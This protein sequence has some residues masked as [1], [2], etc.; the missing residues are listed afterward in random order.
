MFYSNK[1][2]TFFLILFCLHFQGAAVAQVGKTDLSNE[3]FGANSPAIADKMDANVNVNFWG[4]NDFV[5][6]L[7]KF[8]P[9]SSVEFTNAG[10]PSYADRSKYYMATNLFCGP[11]E[12]RDSSGHRITLKNPELGSAQSYPEYYSLSGAYFVWSRKFGLKQ[13]SGPPFPEPLFLGNSQLCRF[14]LQDCFQLEKPGAYLLTV[15]PKIYKKD[16]ITNDICV[17][18][19]LSPVTVPVQWEGNL[20]N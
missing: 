11:V 18:V 14:R 10:L 6:V 2:A 1:A 17:R 20:D 7:V 9:A 16:S 19:D 4:T 8:S 3:E 13:H 12:L 5:S 15:W